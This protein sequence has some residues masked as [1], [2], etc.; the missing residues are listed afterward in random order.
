MTKKV[1][2]FVNACCKCKHPLKCSIFLTAT[3]KKVA[4]ECCGAKDG[5]CV[6]PCDDSTVSH[7]YCS[8]CAKKTV[9]QATKGFFS[10]ALKQEC[11]ARR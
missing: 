9:E 4:K 11:F 10:R 2:V 7:G 1:T 5:C 8:N 6:K 3:G